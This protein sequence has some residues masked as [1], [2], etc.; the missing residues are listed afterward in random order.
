VRSLV[1]RRLGAR[2][3]DARS[4]DAGFTPGFASRL[5]G[6]D[7]SRI[8]V[9]AASKV[10]QRPI[11]AAYAEE[12]R[13]L[14]LLPAGVPAP[15]LLW[16]EEDDLWVVLGFEDV[17]G[18][19]PNRPW[20]HGELT[21]CLDTLVAVDRSLRVV[22]PGLDLVPLHED[23]PTLLTGWAC[24][25]GFQPHWPHLDEL[26]D[27]ARSFAELPDAGHLVHA[28]GRDDNFILADDGRTLL[29]DW[30]WPCLGPRW[31]D[32]VMLLVSVHGDGV[33]AE[34]YLAA[35]PLSAGVPGDHV[36]AFLAA[37]CGFMVEADERPVPSSSPFLGVHRRWWAAAA[38]S[39]LAARRSW[40]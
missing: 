39:W 16:S 10:A 1:E 34:P 4:Q 5:T 35:H 29:C 31:V 25:R 28:D 21:R 12:A 20:V 27:L 36:D 33:D 24:V 26:D 32:V 2:V 6:A 22:P 17:P 14:R 15:R 30:N 19:N 23:L 18:H 9:K 8:F 7:G 11:A 40:A 38:W 13:K 3:V 37:L